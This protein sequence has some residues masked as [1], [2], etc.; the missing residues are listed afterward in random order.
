MEPSPKTPNAPHSIYKFYINLDRRTD[1]RQ[2]F[3]D[4]IT[5]LGLEVER[6]PAITHT[7][8]PI[9]TTRSHLEV[10]KLA[11]QRNY[12]EVVI[13]E[14]DFSFFVSRS[15]WDEILASFP[16]SYDVVML[17]Y[18]IV[19]STPFNEKF[20][21]VLDAQAASCYAVHSRFYDQIIANLERAVELY[22]ANPHCHWLYINDQYWKHLQ[23][24]SNWYASK[25]RAGRQ[26][27]GFSDLK[28]QYLENQY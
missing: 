13:F 20:D 12:P 23:P 22:E 25:L 17:D 27:P 24:H 19:S 28:G 5:K 4:E 14:D 2:E 6:F 11:R 18:Y 3:E 15:Q 1:R 7:V 21:K 8:P 9:G 10:L 26:R 16:E